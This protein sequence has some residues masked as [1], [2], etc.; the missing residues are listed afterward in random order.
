[1]RHGWF[2][3]GLMV[4]LLSPGAAQAASVG[5]RD[6]T[7]GATNIAAVPGDI[8]ELELYLDTEGLS[9]EGYYLGIDFT[10]GPVTIQGVAPQTLGTQI[11]APPGLF[12]EV[13]GLGGTSCPTSGPGCTVSFSGV[14]IAPEPGTG[15]LLAAGLL[16]LALRRSK[17]TF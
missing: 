7:T 2:L 12:S 13:L 3:V 1:M 11:T 6:S 4:L 8:V 9:F 10:G 5:L 15:L 17:L 16:G 14:Q